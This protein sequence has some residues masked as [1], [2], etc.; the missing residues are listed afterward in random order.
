V[1]HQI[2]CDVKLVILSQIFSCPVQ[3]LDAFQSIAIRLF[4]CDTHCMEQHL[5]YGGNVSPFS[6]LFVFLNNTSAD[7]PDFLQM[8][9]EKT[10]ACDLIINVY[11]SRICCVCD[12]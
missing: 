5:L 11:L 2:R 7:N 12:I 9:P 6:Y 3:L 10:A 4:D 1:P 8:C